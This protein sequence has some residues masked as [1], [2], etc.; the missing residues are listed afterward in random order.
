MV[1]SGH[2]E[3]EAF[4]HKVLAE[5]CRFGY[6][7]LI[8]CEKLKVFGGDVREHYEVTAS[9]EAV[10]N[11]QDETFVVIGTLVLLKF[12]ITATD[13]TDPIAGTCLDQIEYESRL[14]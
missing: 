7:V 3:P 10:F 2:F 4:R 9:I 11:A 1:P 14:L 6:S 13:W 12:V 5:S 8:N